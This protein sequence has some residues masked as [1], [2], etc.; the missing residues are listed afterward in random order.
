MVFRTARRKLPVDGTVCRSPIRNRANVAALT[1]SIGRIGCPR[2]VVEDPKACPV[3]T[4][5]NPPDRTPK[6]GGE[7]WF[8]ASSKGEPIAPAEYLPELRWEGFAG[9]QILLLLRY[10]TRT[11]TCDSRRRIWPR[12]GEASGGACAEIC[13]P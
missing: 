1:S 8:G 5:G 13:N 2:V 9:K 3:Q 4:V 10:W 6:A 11:R 7:G 12:C